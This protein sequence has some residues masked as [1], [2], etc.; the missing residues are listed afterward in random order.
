LDLGSGGYGMF[1][2]PNS[3]SYED[4]NDYSAVLKL[5]YNGSTFIR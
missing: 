3:T 4:L 5:E 2:A 1:L